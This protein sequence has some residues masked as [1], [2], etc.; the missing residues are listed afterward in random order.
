MRESGEARDMNRTA[1]LERYL[2]AIQ[3]RDLDAILALFSPTATVSHP[4]FGEQSAA[5]FFPALLAGTAS[6]TPTGTL[7]L[8][9]EGPT[10][11]V[12]FEDDWTTPDGRHFQNPIVLLFDFDPQGLT[13]R[14]RVVFD[15]A[16]LRGGL[17]A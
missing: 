4:V 17:G 14:L 15:T 13:E 2:Q 8:H 9:A 7:L 12:Y 6:D 16:S 11:A 3:A 10:S 1:L 5:E